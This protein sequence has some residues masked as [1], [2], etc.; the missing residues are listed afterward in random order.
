MAKLPWFPFEAT[1]WLSDPYVRVMSAQQRGWYIDLLCW[2]WQEGGVDPNTAQCLCNAFALPTNCQ[3]ELEVVLSH[4]TYQCGGGKIS[5]PKLENIRK[6]SEK[7]S[8]KASESAN[9]RW[10]ANAMP[11]HCESNANKCISNS[12]SSSSSS[13]DLK[14]KRSRKISTTAYLGVDADFEEFWGEYWLKKSKA[15]AFECYKEKVTSHEMHGTILAAV[16]L[17]RMDYLAKEPS[18][19]PHASTWINGKRW[20]DGA[21]PKISTVNGTRQLTRSE[22]IERAF[23]AL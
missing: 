16:A 19:R 5:H 18:S 13:K 1:T 6:E 11:S 17:Q 22:Q 12:S 23:E 20:L 2:C 9:K 8:V 21:D 4:F 15:Y 7:R 10:H 14:K 3:G